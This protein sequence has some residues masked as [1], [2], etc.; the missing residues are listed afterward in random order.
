MDGLHPTSEDRAQAR[1]ELL[2]L[3]TQETDIFCVGILESALAGLAETQGDEIQIRQVLMSRLER[4]TDPGDA[5]HL[6]K[7]IA[8][9]DPTTED[10]E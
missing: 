3:L 4:P 8:E 1:Q 5:E 10:R 6:A 9:L 2:R 7:M